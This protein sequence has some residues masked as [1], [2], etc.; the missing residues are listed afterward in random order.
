LEELD[1]DIER[2]E[3]DSEEVY[4]YAE[5]L[6]QLP[7]VETREEAVKLAVA[8]SRVNKGVEDLS[9]NF[10]EWNVALKSG[11]KGN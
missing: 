4:S 1:K 3:L 9:S 8:N 2:Y 10:E 11:E 6:E 5:A 7:L